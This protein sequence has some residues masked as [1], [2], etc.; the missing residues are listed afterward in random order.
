MQKV[1]WKKER[2]LVVGAGISG[3]A[4]ARLTRDFGADVVLSDTKEKANINFDLSALERQGVRFSFGAQEEDQLDGVTRVI[5]SPA[6]PVRVPLIQAAY[7]RGIRVESEIELA[8]HLARSPI[9]AVTGTNGK[10]TTTMLLGRLLKTVYPVVGI[11][12][13][14]GVALSEEAVHVGAGGAIAAEISSYQ[15]EATADFRPKIAAIL[16]VTPDHVTRHG[17]L[18]VYQEMKEK[19]FS[20]QTQDDFLVLN[21]DNL[22][23]RGMAERAPSTVCFF[24]RRE[25]LESGAFLEDGWLVMRWQGVTHRLLSVRE[26]KLRG[27]HNVENAL[28]ASAMAFLAGAAPAKIAPIL[29]DFSGVEHRIEPVAKVNGVMYYN[30]SKATN[31]D[32]A[33]KALDS[34]P[35]EPIVLIA[36]GEDKM[37]DLTAFMKLVK[38]RCAALILLGAA[39]ARFRA[40]ALDVGIAA[41]KIYEAGYS[42]EKAVTIAYSLARPPQVVLLSPACASFDMFRGYEERGRVFKSL[43]HALPG[44]LPTGEEYAASAG[45][46]G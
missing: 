4:A 7:R 42:L 20:C 36:G 8:Y 13:N 46:E 18:A 6:V 29:R 14:I 10:T 23:T 27:G 32:S 41:G 21:Y 35:G 40:A 28:A 22:P 31:T 39:A 15:L 19:L 34:F 9:F 43:V 38:D 12:G 30:D 24:S 3:L 17:S 37:T 1:D 5:V 16:N 2:I 45:I 26:L 44:T 33:V 11:G 25:K